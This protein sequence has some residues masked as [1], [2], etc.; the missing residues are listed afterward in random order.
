MTKELSATMSIPEAGE[1]LGIGRDCAYE[2][3]RRGE[4]PTLKIG[5]LRRVPRVAFERMLSP[6]SSRKGRRVMRPGTQSSSPE[7]YLWRAVVA[8]AIVDATEP[9]PGRPGHAR[10]RDEAREWL[11]SNSP[12]FRKVCELALLDPAAVRDRA[13][14]LAADGW[15]KQ[16]VLQTHPVH[17]PRG[18]HRCQV[19]NT[20]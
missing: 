3:A 13:E 19:E 20:A 11:L 18:P 17:R 9:P 4:I 1:V 7:L 15:P 6:A 14:Q 2:A 8:Q 12:D 5:R 10:T 16:T